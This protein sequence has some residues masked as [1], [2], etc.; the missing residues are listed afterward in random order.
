MNS[1]QLNGVRYSQLYGLS[2]E[3]D[4]GLTVLHSVIFRVL[5][6][7]IF[8]GNF[9]RNSICDRMVLCQRLFI[10]S[11]PIQIRRSPFRPKTNKFMSLTAWRWLSKCVDGFGRISF[12]REW[13]Q[14][15]VRCVWCGFVGPT[16]K[17][18]RNWSVADDSSGALTLRWH[19]DISFCQLLT[20]ALPSPFSRPQITEIRQLD[21]DK[22][23]THTA[24]PTGWKNIDDF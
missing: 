13:N 19:R 6:K 17:L 16:V 5:W 2:V 21:S 1:T 7:I 22:M 10:Y 20:S 9:R 4:V 18:M 24:K 12:A 14:V 11:Y 15:P 3:F 23:T 8:L